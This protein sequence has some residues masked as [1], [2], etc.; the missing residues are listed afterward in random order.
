MTVVVVDDHQLFAEAISRYALADPAG[1]AIANSLSWRT[2]TVGSQDTARDIASRIAL[3]VDVGPHDIV[4]INIEL[5]TVDSPRC[6]QAG[7]DVLKWLRLT[8]DFGDVRSVH[9]IVYAFQ[10]LEQLLRR[11]PDN[12]ILCSPGTTFCR[13]PSLVPVVTERLLKLANEKALVN[14]RALAPFVRAGFRLP[15]E[16]HAWANEWAARQI[17]RV[18]L[19][20]GDGVSARGD[21]TVEPIT[22]STFRD[23][24][25]LLDASSEAAFTPNVDE[26]ITDLRARIGIQ[27]AGRTISMIDDQGAALGGEAALGWRHVYSDMTGLDTAQITDGLS[28]G[29]DVKSICALEITLVDI[30]NRLAVLPALASHGSTDTKE[31]RSDLEARREALIAE[32]FVILS[33]AIP[34]DCG[35]VL[36][37]LR[38][39]PA[40]ADLPYAQMSGALVLQ[41]LRRHYPTLPV[42]MST[43]SNKLVALEAME[44]L[45]GD[46]YWVKQG[47]DE[48]RTAE[49]TV[50]NCRRLLTLIQKATGPKYQFLHRYGQT[51]RSLRDAPADSHWWE[52]ASWGALVQASPS[53]VVVLVLL[54]ETVAAIRRYLRRAEMGYGYN[55]SQ[56]DRFTVWSVLQHLGKIVEEIHRFDLVEDPS[57]GLI[58][59]AWEKGLT[60]QPRV[61]KGTTGDVLTGREDWFGYY[62]YQIRNTASHLT[63]ARDS[64]NW[65]DLCTYASYVLAYAMAGPPVRKIDPRAENIRRRKDESGYSFNT[66]ALTFLLKKPQFGAQ[67]RVFDVLVD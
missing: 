20:Y 64:I 18:T 58:G 52:Q 50:T 67:R 16:R 26:E 23:A 8:E 10:T 46:A 15:D 65:A 38:L 9:C 54:E 55:P 6:H 4:L 11:R 47:I 27:M 62:L 51:V 66:R 63:R 43:A 25:Y 29:I 39:A 7:V 13:L 32:Q 17:R 42:V 41:A 21:S 33:A 45:G 49:E 37:D 24:L 53:R 3:G 19:L 1:N 34:G 59:S 28:D 12:L 57:S 14:H 5:K 48:H 2:V 60:T 56:D 61:F 22:D 36:L 35:C 44:R 30:D 31:L 40:D